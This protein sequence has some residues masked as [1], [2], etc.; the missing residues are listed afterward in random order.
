MQSYHLI[1]ASSGVREYCPTGGFVHA[2]GTKHSQIN[3][4]E[5]G[6]NLKEFVLKDVSHRR[7]EFSPFPKRS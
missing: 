3:N 5:N 1:K 2:A 7:A 4:K 6:M